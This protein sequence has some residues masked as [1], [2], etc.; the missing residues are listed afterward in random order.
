[1]S[2]RKLLSPDKKKIVQ[3]TYNDMLINDIYLKQ[4]N[5]FKRGFYLSLIRENK[6]I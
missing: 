5:E 6:E 2:F 1:M 4:P 3:K